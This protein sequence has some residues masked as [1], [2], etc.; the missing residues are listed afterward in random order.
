MSALHLLLLCC[1]FSTLPWCHGV[2]EAETLSTRDL[3]LNTP[4]RG[5]TLLI[6]RETVRYVPLGLAPNT[7]YEARV[8]YP[9]TNPARVRLWLEGEVQGSARMLLDAERI[10]FRSDARGRMVGTDRNPGAILMRAERW[11]M[12]RDGEAGAPKQLAYDIVMERSVLGVP[13]SAGPIILVAAALL[14]VV[15]AALPWWTHRAVPALLDWLA[16]D[17]PTARRRL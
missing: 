10:I 16:Q 15:A 2:G 14:V 4:R 7:T 5:D 8:S 6:G 3:L 11:A 12:H 9:A 13:S 1:L 17:A